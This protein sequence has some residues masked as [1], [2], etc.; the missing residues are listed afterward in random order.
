MDAT[1]AQGN[2]LDPQMRALQTK[3]LDGLTKMLPLTATPN[4][5]KAEIGELLSTAGTKQGAARTGRET[6]QA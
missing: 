6:C 4:M 1:R 3:A 2:L 5:P